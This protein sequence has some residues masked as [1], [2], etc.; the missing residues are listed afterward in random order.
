MMDQLEAVRAVVTVLNGAEPTDNDDTNGIADLTETATALVIGLEA[1]GYRIRPAPPLPPGTARVE[2]LAHREFAT[3]SPAGKVRIEGPP[4][5]A[6][7]G[8]F[9]FT[10]QG[11]WLGIVLQPGTV[12]E[13]KPESRIIVPGLT[14]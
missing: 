2:I 4:E 11:V 8:A 3:L 7:P 10:P 12:Y 5:K 13:I 14:Q 6:G 9:V 1:A